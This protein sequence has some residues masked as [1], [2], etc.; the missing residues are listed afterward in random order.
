[1]PQVFTAT[2]PIS[3]SM[4]ELLISIATLYKRPF[5]LQY[6]DNSPASFTMVLTLSQRIVAKQ[7]KV[8]VGMAGSSTTVHFA[9]TH[10]PVGHLAVVP[11][12]PQ[13]QNYHLNS[14]PTADR[15]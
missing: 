5:C 15:T 14:P 3:I 6:L 10:V 1:M 9:E 2:V 11:T 7:F 8:Y 12:P 13:A 4:T